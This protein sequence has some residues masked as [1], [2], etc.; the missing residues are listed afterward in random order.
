MQDQ[1]QMQGE[2]GRN[3]EIGA[4]RR[5]ARFV[6][7]AEAKLVAHEIS[8]LCALPSRVAQSG[9]DAGERIDAPHEIVRELLRRCGM[10][11]RLAGDG[12]YAREHVLDPVIE[13]TNQ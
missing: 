6:D 4:A 10:A 12:L 8:K 7:G 13:L 3:K 1:R 11:Q 2:L 9:V 5:D